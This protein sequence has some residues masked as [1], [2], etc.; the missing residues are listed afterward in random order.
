MAHGRGKKTN[1][2][3][4]HQAHADWVAWKKAGRP[5]RPSKNPQTQAWISATGRGTVSNA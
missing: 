3:K 1:N 2:N 5:L 4:N